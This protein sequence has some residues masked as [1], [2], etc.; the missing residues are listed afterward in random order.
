M[1]RMKMHFPRLTLQ[2]CRLAEEERAPYARS[3]ILDAEQ[4]RMVVD[5]F[6]EMPM[7][8]PSE[9]DFYRDG[10]LF[11]PH[12][13]GKPQLAGRPNMCQAITYQ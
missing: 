5:F 3:S 4:T 11:C 8:L 9:A 1:L 2:A 10:S 6:S 7:P 13:S 12:F